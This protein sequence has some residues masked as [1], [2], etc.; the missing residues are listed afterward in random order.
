M[1]DGWLVGWLV[2]CFV[3]GLLVC[4]LVFSSRVSTILTLL[5]CQ[6]SN[7]MEQASVADV[8]PGSSRSKMRLFANR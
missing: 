3:M 4:L 2:F 6:Q 1:F 5:D 8:H 7:F